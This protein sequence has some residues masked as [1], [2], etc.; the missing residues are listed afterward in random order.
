[1]WPPKPG[2]PQWRQQYEMNK[3]A[4][5]AV[6]RKLADSRN[7]EIMPTDR[8]YDAANL[9]FLENTLESYGLQ[10]RLLA[11]LPAQEVEDISKRLQEL[12]ASLPAEFE[13]VKRLGVQRNKLFDQMKEAFES[14]AAAS[15]Q[16]KN[17]RG[18]SNFDHDDN[19]TW[20]T[21]EGKVY[22]ALTTNQ[23]AVIRCLDEARLAG[24]SKLRKEDLGQRAG[25][26]GKE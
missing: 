18:A 11:N 24:H 19:Y 9:Q 4:A 14:R 12:A 13:E 7:Y 22:D 10:E 6:R 1:M 15:P 17:E 8:A 21:F 16:A 20:I 2:G 25:I 26:G 3:V 5:E 23:S